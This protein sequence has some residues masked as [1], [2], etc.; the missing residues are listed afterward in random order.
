MMSKEIN[1][2]QFKAVAADRQSDALIK[3]Q[4]ELDHIQNS[5]ISPSQL[6]ELLF[7]KMLDMYQVPQI[8]E[9]RSQ[10]VPS[11]LDDPKIKQT[12]NSHGF[13]RKSSN[14]IH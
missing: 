13:F 8:H 7:Q 6:R 14:I 5:G 10:E 1:K 12:L 3:L 9:L 4:Q 11:R 2:Q